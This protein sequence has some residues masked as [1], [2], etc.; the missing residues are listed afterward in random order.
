MNFA[1]EFR[2]EKLA[3]TLLDRIKKTAIRPIRLMEVCGGH[4]MAIRR[5]GIH[6]LLPDTIDLLSGP[7]C[8]VC[9]TDQLYIDLAVAY[10]RRPDTMLVSYG[11]M[12]RVPGSFTSLEKEK[13]SGA[14]IRVVYSTLQALDLARSN[15]NKTIVF[16]A[17]GFETTTPGTALAILQAEK[18][19]LSNFKIICAHKTMPEAMGALIQEGVN[20][21]G[22]IGPGHVSSIAGSQL[23]V[24][25]AEKYRIPVVI[26]GFEPLDLLQTILMLAEMI[27]D[28][29]PGVKI[30]YKR[31]VTREGN[32]RAQKIVDTVFEP[33]EAYW[34]GIG[35]IAGSGLGLR[36]SYNVFDAELVIPVPVKTGPEPR[37]CMCGNILKGLNKPSDC[38]L[39]GRKCTPANPVGACMVSSEGACNAYMQYQI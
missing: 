29:E 8:P 32:T 6:T 14:D 5:Y 24:P 26:A 18:E 3:R 11:D 34:R 1:N 4:T 15:R 33:V 22:Y 37:G 9:V 10:A 28:G 2:D 27:A 30:Q 25:L 36:A 17:I 21:D 38:P 20:I 35:R 39:F 23:F 12:L 19:K 13:A 16:A 31:L 7:G